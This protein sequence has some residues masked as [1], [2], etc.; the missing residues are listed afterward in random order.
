MLTRDGNEVLIEEIVDTGT[1]QA[2]IRTHYGWATKLVITGGNTV[3]AG[4]PLLLAVAYWDWQGNPLPDENQPVHITVT[5]PGQA[6]ELALM[7][8]NGQAE[9]DFVSAVA[10]TF[11]I[12]AT[13]EFPCDPTELEVAVT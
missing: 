4:A 7:P 2:I 6:Q 12:R 13:A 10:G 1:Q 8:T 5:G 11:K 9:F 3:T